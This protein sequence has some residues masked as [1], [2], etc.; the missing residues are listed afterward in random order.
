MKSYKKVLIGCVF[1]LVSLAV[2]YF[3]IQWIEASKKSELTEVVIAKTDLEADQVLETSDLE[4]MTIPTS[5]A[6]EQYLKSKGLVAGRHL[7][8]PIKKGSPIT[9]EL[10]LNAPKIEKR[11]NKSV[12]TL[13]LAPEEAL[14]WQI[15]VGEAVDIAYVDELTKSF[16]LLGNVTI[17]GVFDHLVKDN[18]M[19]TY[20]L[21]SGD[22]HIIHAIVSTRALGKFEIL[23]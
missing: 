15:E 18:A 5:N 21:V 6:S 11:E 19:P 4:V 9:A 8:V 20:L 1:L 17:E 7:V 22:K 16:T 2:T 3:E 23:K 10:L 12:T 14:A 13:K